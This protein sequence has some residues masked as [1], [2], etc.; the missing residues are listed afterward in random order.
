MDTGRSQNLKKVLEA[1]PTGNVVDAAWLASH[2]ERYETFRDDVKRG[3]LANIVK[4]FRP[5]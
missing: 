4:D 2:G 1:V 5:S 3:W